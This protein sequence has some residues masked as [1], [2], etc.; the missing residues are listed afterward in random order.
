MGAPRGE[1]G[2]NADPASVRRKG[3]RRAISLLALPIVLWWLASFFFLGDLGRQGDDYVVPGLAPD[4]SV[5]DWFI[6]PLEGWYSFWRPLHIM[7]YFNLG[8]WLKDAYWLFHLLTAGAFGLAFVSLYGLMREVR[9]ATMP[10]LTA[11]M[12]LMAHP[13]NFEA[14]HWNATISTSLAAAML[15]AMGILAV[16][17]IR[18]EIRTRW[19]WAMP[20]LGFALASL[21]EQPASG[22][23]ALP[24]LALGAMASA[25]ARFSIHSLTRAVVPSIL[26]GVGVLA[27]LGAIIADAKKGTRQSSFVSIEHVPERL[28][29]TLSEFGA[30][31]GGDRFL[32]SL[33]GGLELAWNVLG[34]WG[35]VSLAMIL[36]IAGIATT[37]FLLASPS[38]DPRVHRAES[39]GEG[40]LRRGLLLAGGLT[41]AFAGLLPMALIE[42]QPVPART[43]LFPLLGVAL[44]AGVILD[45]LGASATRLAAPAQLAMRLGILAVAAIWSVAGSLAL[46]GAQA[47]FRDRA[48]ADTDAVALVAALS[49]RV[50]PGTVFLPLAA[51]PTSTRTGFPG[52]DRVAPSAWWIPWAVTPLVRHA[53]ERGDVAS[54]PLATVPW[55]SVIEAFEGGRLALHHVPRSF[56]EHTRPGEAQRVPLDRII[57][58]RF[59]NDGRL[60]IVPTLW[61]M[62][63]DHRDERLEFPAALALA[64]SPAQGVIVDPTPAPQ[65]VTVPDWRWASDAS[66]VEHRQTWAWGARVPAADVSLADRKRNTMR[67]RLGPSTLARRICVR[68]TVIERWHEKRDRG[69]GVSV[70]LEGA[71]ERAETLLDRAAFQGGGRWV[72]IEIV[73]PPSDSPTLVRVRLEAGP[74][75]DRDFDRAWITPGIVEHIPVESSDA[76]PD[77][78]PRPVERGGDA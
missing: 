75:G 29:L 58:I 57:P 71:G 40:S 41:W 56:V 34:G 59:S 65:G 26:Y 46:L 2:I 11:S 33:G 68:A 73:I 3:F 69:D 54:A 6:D 16:R 44:S 23:A 35:V 47:R 22:L 32:Q 63:E 8:T 77:L 27:Y 66:R 53:M 17:W 31:L 20:V 45:W 4:G 39:A 52:F 19:L 25:R 5:R 38:V 13:A 55:V 14:A 64:E 10:A 50:P 62:R 24:L 60:E 78:S 21:N 72:P 76:A 51:P 30:W 9:L 43:T 18:S 1:S 36:M 15:C 70:V 74:T 49:D 12:A 37:R 48:S 7:L 28:S 67:L 61:L 42:G